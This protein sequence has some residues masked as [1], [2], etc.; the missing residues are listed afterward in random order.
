M[1]ARAVVRQRAGGVAKCVALVEAGVEARGSYQVPVASQPAGGPPKRKRPIDAEAAAPAAVRPR[2][3]GVVS[4]AG[5]NVHSERGE[6][7]EEG[8]EEGEG[9]GE[10]EINVGD[11]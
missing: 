11:E 4:A 9:E 8:E 10:G 1:R 2:L 5:N 6:E 3:E 7:E